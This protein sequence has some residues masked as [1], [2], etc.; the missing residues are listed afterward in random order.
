MKLSIYGSPW[1]DLEEILR[2][3]LL[4]AS[5]SNEGVIYII[6]PWISDI[7]LDQMLI[8][9]PRLMCNSV[10]EALK[11][12]RI[13]FKVKVVTR[14]YDDRISPAKLYI[15]NLLAQEIKS[16]K[17]PALVTILGEVVEDLVK[18]VESMRMIRA[19]IADNIE[20]RFL[21]NLHAKIYLSP[22]EALVG[23][24]NLTISGMKSGSRYANSEVLLRISREDPIYEKILH[25]AE[26]YFKIGVNEEECVKNLLKKINETLSEFGSRF[27]NLHEIE[28]FVENL[29]DL[30]LRSM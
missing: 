13:F 1:N 23:S 3:F 17:S 9:H 11:Q 8:C 2:D 22:I 15:A 12:L 6:S 25:L 10:L 29:R 4:R 20:V 18:A 27:N 5:S 21:Y 19:L 7:P 28:T 30:Y 14:C 24:A 16:K 26:Q